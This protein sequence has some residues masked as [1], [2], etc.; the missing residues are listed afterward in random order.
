MAT[1]VK[2][3]V[4][5]TVKTTKVSAEGLVVHDLTEMKLQKSVK[6]IVATEG[7]DAAI[8]ECR[9][10]VEKISRECRMDNV[11]YRDPHF[12]LSEMTTFCLNGLRQTGEG[13]EGVASP[14]G[15]KRVEEI[16]DDPKFIVDGIDAG[17]INQ[18]SAGDCWFL[19]AVATIA[20]MPNLL[21]SICV[22]RDERTLCVVVC[23][24][25]VDMTHWCV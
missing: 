9:R 16:Y 11:K 22:A 14:G 7:R 4:T 24:V 25:M 20:N 15:V 23:M 2:K 19:A 10:K 12:D 3:T 5:K 18:G 17:D 21:E 8:R 13:E 6:S 1:V